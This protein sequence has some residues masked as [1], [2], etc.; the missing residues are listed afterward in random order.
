MRAISLSPPALGIITRTCPPAVSGTRLDAPPNTLAAPMVW[1]SANKMR[2]SKLLKPHSKSF[3]ASS[4]RSFAVLRPLTTT[5][6]RRPFCTAE[7]TRP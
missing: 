6:S 2:C 3:L 5:T 7:P 1:P 4:A